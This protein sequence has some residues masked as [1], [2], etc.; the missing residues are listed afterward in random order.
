MG[1]ALYDTASRGSFGPVGVRDDRRNRG[2]GA[3]LLMQSL[4]AMRGIGYAY[5]FVID[6]GPEEFYANVCNATVIENA[7]TRS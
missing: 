1:F 6:I 5:A 2:I 3:S 7:S 4:E